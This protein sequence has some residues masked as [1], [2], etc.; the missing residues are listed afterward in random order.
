[1]IFYYY[2]CRALTVLF[3]YHLH[4]LYSIPYFI[5]PPTVAFL[6]AVFTSIVT[7]CFDQVPFNQWISIIHENK[8][9]TTYNGHYLPFSQF[10]YDRWNIKNPLN[11]FTTSRWTEFLFLSRLIIS[12][13]QKYCKNI[14]PSW[15]PQQAEGS[16][17]DRVKAYKS[18]RRPKKLWWKGEITTYWSGCESTQT[19][20][21]RLRML[22]SLRF[23]AVHCR[24][25][26]DHR[27]PDYVWYHVILMNLSQSS[28]TC[29]QRH[30]RRADNP[31][32]TF[33]FEC[34]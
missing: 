1:M 5:I 9:P 31:S 24:H 4:Y 13:L 15:I 18:S 6:D 3:G 20:G 25:S 26:W 22:S 32:G 33:Y 29:R 28:W 14:F 10:I 17:L 34:S 7:L 2:F 19:Y 23:D 16:N 11:P 30:Q 8:R 27:R 12:I 21:K